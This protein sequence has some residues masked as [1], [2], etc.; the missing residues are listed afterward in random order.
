LVIIWSTRLA[1][2]LLALLCVE[3]AASTA[4]ND[5]ASYGGDAG[6]THYSSLGQITRGTVRKLQEV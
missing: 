4:G 3:S 1:L 6:G 2:L 5:W